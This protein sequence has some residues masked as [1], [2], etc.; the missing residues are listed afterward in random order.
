MKYIVQISYNDFTF[1]DKYDAMN[2]AETAAITGEDVE[3]IR[4]YF[5]QEEEKAEEKAEEQ[6]EEA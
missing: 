6:E 4:I 1:Y 5:A 2:F 3:R